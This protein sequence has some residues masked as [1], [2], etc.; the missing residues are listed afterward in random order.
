MCGDGNRRRDLELVN[1]QRPIRRLWSPLC[2]HMLAG[3][4]QSSHAGTERIL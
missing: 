1:Q 3:S 2:Q 4:A